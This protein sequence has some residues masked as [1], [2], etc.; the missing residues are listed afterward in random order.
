MDKFNI[1]G[2]KVLNTCNLKLKKPLMSKFY[3]KI[4]KF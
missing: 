2:N 1:K 4:N 3:L